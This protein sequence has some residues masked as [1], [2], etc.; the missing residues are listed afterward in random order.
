MAQIWVPGPAE[1]HVGV[2][3]GGGGSVGAGYTYGGALL[4]LGWSER[5]VRISE[6]PE[7][8]DVPADI[9]GSRVP[10]DVQ[11]MSEQCFVSLDL[12]V[13]NQPV[14]NQIASRWNPYSGTPG[15]MTVGSIGSLM[16]AENLAYRLLVFPPYQALK[17]VM[18]GLRPYNFQRA[19]L[20]GPDDINPFGMRAMKQRMI[21]RAIPP[22]PD[23]SGNRLLYNQDAS[24][25]PVAA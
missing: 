11:F 12:K 5:G 17:P 25:K 16:I 10:Q 21:F 24:G 18:S 23:G 8:E 14:Y 19:W 2:G 20:A 1:I 6:N 15:L 9:A 4:F 13:W 22:Y 3:A 7:W